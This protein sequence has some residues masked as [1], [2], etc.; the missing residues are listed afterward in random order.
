MGV[1]T[2]YRLSATLLSVNM[3]SYPS[4]VRTYTPLKYSRRSR[5]SASADIKTYILRV[6]A[7]CTRRCTCEARRDALCSTENFTTSFSCVQKAAQ[8][9]NCKGT[10]ERVHSNSEESED[11]MVVQSTSSVRLSSGLPFERPCSSQV[12]SLARV[13][14]TPRRRKFTRGTKYRYVPWESQYV[15]SASWGRAACGRLT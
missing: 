13:S 14:R 3:C 15:R 8:T 4:C 6:Y 7:P 10:G 5:I 11:V 12:T 9:F 2:F 1:C